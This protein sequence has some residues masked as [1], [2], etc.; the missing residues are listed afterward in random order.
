MAALNVLKPDFEQKQ[1]SYCRNDNMI[2][3]LFHQNAYTSQNMF[4]LMLIPIKIT[5]AFKS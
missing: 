2:E 3:R 1:Q 5:R 4:Y